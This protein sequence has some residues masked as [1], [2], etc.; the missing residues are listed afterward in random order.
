MEKILNLRE[1]K[2]KDIVENMGKIQNKLKMQR[3]VLDELKDD[4][5]KLNKTGFQ[6][7]LDLQYQ[8]LCKSKIREDIDIQTQIIDEISL[9]LEETRRDLIEAQK[10]RKVMEKLKEKDKDKY[11]E[12]IRYEEQRELDEI[13]VLKFNS[14]GLK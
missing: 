3:D 11:Y 5:D 4:A 6:N 13:A 2:E 9:M 12:K 7:I 10:D 8:N 14:E 1:T